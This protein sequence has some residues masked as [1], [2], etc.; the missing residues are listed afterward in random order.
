IRQM[1]CVDPNKRLT[2]AGVLEHPWLAGDH[3]NTARIERSM[4]SSSPTMK[5]MKRPACDE[6]TVMDADGTTPSTE[7]NSNGR[8]K[9]VKY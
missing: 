2:I 1:M 5:S 9:R 7:S 8:V 3:G 4:F 6:D